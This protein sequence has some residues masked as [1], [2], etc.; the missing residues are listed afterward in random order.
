[1]DFSK[2]RVYLRA[3]EIEDFKTTH[4]WHGDEDIIKSVVGRKYF[5]SKEY[6]KKWINDAIFPSGNYLKLAV[7]MKEKDKHVGNVYL[8]SIDNFNC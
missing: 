3:F 5:V 4:L 6:E 1:M 2:F 7:C 8:N